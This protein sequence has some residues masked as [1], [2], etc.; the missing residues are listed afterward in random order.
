MSRRSKGG[1]VDWLLR[2]VPIVAIV[3]GIA[4]LAQ[5]VVTDWM[6][7]R[8][9]EESIS[10]VITVYNDMDNE[11]RLENLAQ[12][13]A[14]NARLSGNTYEEPLGGIWEYEIQ[15]TY[16][17]TPSTMMSYVDISKIATRL[18]IYHYATTETLS[19]GVGHVEWS[20]LPVGGEGTR[21]II[22]AHS[23]MQDTRMFD[24]IDKL[25]VGDIFVL[26]TLSEPYAYRVCEIETILPEQVEKLAAE[27]GRDLAT[28]VT[29]TPYGV[30]THRLCV[31]GERCEYVEEQAKTEGLAPYVNR[32][33]IPLLACLGVVTLLGVLLVSIFITRCICK[34][35]RTKHT[36]RK[37]KKSRK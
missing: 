30:N 6:Y 3:C 13:R 2:I 19:A 32:R 9:A 4:L 36:T 7:A 14:Y 29:C 12:A 23:G 11:T 31:T 10:E 27:P 8:E 24:D 34:K 20:A 17:G 1:L 25:E 37:N 28:L 5:P 18:P 21:C 22:S 35:K 15:L 33:T 16:Q 26:W